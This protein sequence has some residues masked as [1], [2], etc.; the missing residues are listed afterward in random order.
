MT[1][2]RS[3]VAMIGPIGKYSVHILNWPAPQGCGA[4]R[5]LGL[6]PSQRDPAP[7][8]LHGATALGVDVTGHC[9]PLGLA[10]GSGCRPRATP[11][12]CRQLHD[13]N[14]V[15]KCLCRQPKNK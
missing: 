2:S 15:F 9:S 4:G 13:S 12:L 3:R 5:N 10:K 7:S 6:L 8:L 11:G 1:A 14:T